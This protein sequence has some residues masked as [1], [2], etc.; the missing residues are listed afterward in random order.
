MRGD[1]QAM[2]PMQIAGM[3]RFQ[4]AGCV[5]CH[6]GPMLSDF[7][8]HVLGVPDSPRLANSDT[9]IGNTYAFRTP[10]LRNLARTAPYMHSGV[11]F[12]LEEV[13]RFYTARRDREGL[14]S[15]NR[16][17]PSANLDP[18]FRQVNVRGS[19]REIVAFLHALDDDTFDR[20]I[21]GRVP[22]GL[23]VGGRIVE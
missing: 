13:L 18:L 11:F 20:T 2:N 14:A 23:R 16:H 15:R 3:E 12:S 6:N 1:T 21:P 8:P 7:K 17:V 4:A 19:Q 9:G 22:S 5:K 10:S